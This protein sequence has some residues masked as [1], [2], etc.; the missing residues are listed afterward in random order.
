MRLQSLPV[1]CAWERSYARGNEGA[2]AENMWQA[3]ARFADSVANK[4]L[5][6]IDSQK[7]VPRVFN[8]TYLRLCQWG[9]E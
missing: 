7:S 5:L 1:P 8:N 9:R 6:G 3:S 4:R 2:D